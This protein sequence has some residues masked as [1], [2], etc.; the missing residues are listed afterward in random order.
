MLK[1]FNLKS[2]YSNAFF[3][4]MIFVSLLIFSNALFGSMVLPAFVFGNGIQEKFGERKKLT[5]R[6]YFNAI[7]V[8][9]IEWDYLGK[10]EVQ[11]KEADILTI[12]SD[13][14]IL[15]L[16]DVESKEKIFLDSETYLPLKV[17]RDVL[18]F[19]RKELIEEF[20]NQKEGYV[21]IVKTDSMT[22][23]EFIYQDAPIY[24]ILTLLYF[25]PKNISLSEQEVFIFNLPTQKVRIKVLPARILKINGE[26]KETYFLTGKGARRF[27]LW[28]D[29]EERI[30]LRLEFISLAGKVTVLKE[31]SP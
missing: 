19:G 9:K 23:E 11:G 10:G 13:A 2:G 29:K 14:K 3:R 22:R 25:F 16:L 26:K 21:K 30:P 8:G 18:F 31:K 27:N 6:V 20:Y 17:E 12:D 4:L 28:L 24:H 1:S 5:Y 7:P 15:K